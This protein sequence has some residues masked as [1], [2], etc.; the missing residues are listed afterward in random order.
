MVS[1]LTNFSQY[2]PRNT[3]LEILQ[4]NEIRKWRLSLQDFENAKIRIGFTV[5]ASLVAPGDITAKPQGAIS[6]PHLPG[7]TIPFHQTPSH[8]PGTGS[9]P[10]PSLTP[11][12]QLTFLVGRLHR[13]A[14]AFFHDVLGLCGVGVFW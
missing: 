7:S 14:L 13:A 11:I 5:S 3:Q 12:A 10:T 6:L 9:F 2:G 8:L 4:R 1:M